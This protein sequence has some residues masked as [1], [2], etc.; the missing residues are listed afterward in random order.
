MKHRVPMLRNSIRAG[1]MAIQYLEQ[2]RGEI[3]K[4]RPHLSGADQEISDDLLRAIDTL[5]IEAFR[6]VRLWRESEREM[7]PVVEG[8]AARVDEIFREAKDE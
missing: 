2:E 7:T 5:R 3:V 4:A 6:C 8:L 1:E